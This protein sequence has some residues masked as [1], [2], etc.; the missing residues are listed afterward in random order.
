MSTNLA[1]GERRPSPGDGDARRKLLAGIPVSER[2]L[3]LADVSTALLEGGEGPDMLLLHGPA[4]YGASWHQALRGLVTTHHVIAPDLP[5]HGA[6][7]KGDGHLD[8]ARVTA[9]LGELIEQTC[10]TPPVLVGQLVGGA[11]AARFAADHGERLERLVLVTP[12]GLAPLEPSPAFGAALMGFLS[13]PGEETHDELWAHCVLDLE[14]L[15]R[16]PGAR[17][18]LLKAYSLD[19]LRTTQVIEATNELMEEFATSPIPEATLARIAVPSTLIWG[20]HDS[21]VPLSVAEAA[22]A[23]YGWPLR[24][25]ENAGNEPALEAPD[26]FLHALLSDLTPQSEA[27]V[28]K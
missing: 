18:D 26:A 20:R 10:T 9:W 17:W 24:V 4:A 25:I 15:R 19:V 22:S 27:N 16:Q 14:A 23:R 6:S 12:L 13:H 11:I 3:E 21:I 7:A 5:G 1:T 8:R 28:M 2:R